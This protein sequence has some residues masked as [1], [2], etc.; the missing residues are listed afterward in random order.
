MKALEVLNELIFDVLS[1]EEPTLSVGEVAEKFAIIKQ[2]LLRLQSL[3]KFKE[4]FDKYELAKKQD[5]I[6]YENWQECEKELTK[7]DELLALKNQ[8]IDILN[9]DKGISH[10]EYIKLLDKIKALESEL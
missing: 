6:A 2:A 3:E 7:R 4:T 1:D 5:F 10:L 9:Q 8:Q